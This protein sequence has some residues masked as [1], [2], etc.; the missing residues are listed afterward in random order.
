MKNTSINISGKLPKGL[1]ELYQDVINSAGKFNV[2]VLVVGA[3]ARD[4]ILVYGY[5]AKMERGTRD[6][7]FGVNVATWKEFEVLKRELIQIGFK[8]NSKMQHRLERNDSHGHLWE[9]DIIPFGEIA[10][11]N[12]EISWPPDADFVMSIL[13]FEEVYLHS[14]ETKISE[15]PVVVISVAS[16]AG[17][18]LLK[19]IAWLE[20]DCDKKVKDAEDINYIIS[21]HSKIPE[22]SGAL[23]EEGYMEAQDW[24]EDLA[25]AQK[26][27]ID[28]AMIA[29]EETAQFLAEN[30]LCQPE[31]LEQL[32]R[33][34]P[35]YGY[36]S[37]EDL[38]TVFS[39]SFLGS[40][41]AI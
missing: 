24:D 1:V 4:L 31:K 32:I 12:K 19:L 9:I 11:A 33:G 18:V 39:E 38:L 26:M 34:M 30:L 40:K 14:I 37:P 35:G 23:Y 29:T 3:M 28:C 2:R 13:G 20:R 17:I 10:N 5:G 25:S 36:S 16:P 6:V 21:S 22:I 27:G 7:D 15:T 41:K 8:E